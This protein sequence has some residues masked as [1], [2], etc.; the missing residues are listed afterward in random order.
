SYDAHVAEAAVGL[1][2]LVSF[3]GIVTFPTA[4]ALR[5][6]ARSVPLDRV[7]IETDSPFLAPVPHRGKRNEPAYVVH[8][9]ETLARLRN[10]SVAEVAAATTAN[11]DRL[12]RLRH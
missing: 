8:V 6:A 4:G 5:E 11:F 9:A 12:F 2:V 10:I 3:S 1:G 7:L